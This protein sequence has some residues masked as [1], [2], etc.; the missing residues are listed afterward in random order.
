METCEG[1]VQGEEAKTFRKTAAFSAS[2]SRW[3]LVSLEYP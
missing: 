2:A 1:S 3:G